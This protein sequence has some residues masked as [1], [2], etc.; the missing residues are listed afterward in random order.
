[1]LSTNK[2]LDLQ[3]RTKIAFEGMMG[4][5]K[6][7]ERGQTAVEYA[8]IAF[9]VALLAVVLF[10]QRDAIASAVGQKVVEA[11]GRITGG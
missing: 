8:G 2:M 5:I 1:M 3:I 4:R 9:F 7:S 11:I 6:D 10:N